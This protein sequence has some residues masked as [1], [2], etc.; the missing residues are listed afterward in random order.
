ML[1]LLKARSPI[2]SGQPLQTPDARQEDMFSSLG[3]Y[4]GWKAHHV[5]SNWLGRIRVRSIAIVVSNDRI[6]F[7]AS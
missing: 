7:G 4:E 3:H 2:R 6:F 1:L 5:F